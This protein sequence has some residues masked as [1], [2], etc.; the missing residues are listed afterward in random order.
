MDEKNFYVYEHL[1]E[2]GTVF[3]VGQGSRYRATSP[4]SRSK[5]WNDITSKNNYKVNIVKDNLTEQ[6]SLELE[7][8]LILKHG[9]HEKGLGTLIN[10][11]DG[12]I[13]LK[14]ED[15]HFYGVQLFGENNG[16]FGNKYGSNTLSKAILMLDTKGVII[17]E[18]ASL[19]EA[20]ELY[21]Y[22]AACISGCCLGKRQ[23]HK[24]MQ[25]V[26]KCDYIETKDYTY[27]P[28]KTSKQQIVCGE[29]DNKGDITFIKSYDSCA[30][31]VNDNY[32]AKCV[33]ACITGS[34]KTHKN[35]YWFKV[36]SLPE[37]AREYIHTNKI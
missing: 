37:E 5:S 22:D 16:N 12:G 7:A 25:F 27:K 31:V 19:S 24:G 9:R 28:G 30:D 26:Y 3:Y 23:L 13:G 14:G 1:L 29:I 34:K 8:E 18:F 15:N 6:E 33:S 35:L 2:D 17:K 36:L 4:Y 32:N 11:N 21:N 10:H 20:E